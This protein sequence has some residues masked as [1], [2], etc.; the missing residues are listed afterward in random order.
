[1]KKLMKVVKMR[2]N[3]RDNSKKM[4]KIYWQKNGR[5]FWLFFDKNS[6]KVKSKKKYKKIIK[7]ESKGK[8]KKWLKKFVDFDNFIYDK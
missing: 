3:F 8:T 1:M 2:E 4:Q 6:R 7:K 5:K